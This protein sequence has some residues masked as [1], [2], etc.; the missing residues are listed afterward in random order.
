MPLFVVVSQD[1][2]PTITSELHIVA[3]DIDNISVGLFLNI[4]IEQRN[5]KHTLSFDK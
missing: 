2:G 1:E 4:F 3:S 5:H